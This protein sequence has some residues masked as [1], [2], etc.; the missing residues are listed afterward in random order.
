MH[1]NVMVGFLLAGTIGLACAQTGPGTI[2]LD[3]AALVLARSAHRS[4][5]SEYAA[6]EIRTGVCHGK[7]ADPPQRRQT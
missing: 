4:G 5:T 3:P 1:R 2:L 7:A 6:H